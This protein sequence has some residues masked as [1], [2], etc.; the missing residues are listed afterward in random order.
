MLSDLTFPCYLTT[1]RGRKCLS[2]KVICDFFLSRLSKF[3][4]SLFM[5]N[6]ICVVIS[7]IYILISFLYVILYLYIYICSCL[8]ARTMMNFLPLWR[9]TSQGQENSRWR[10]PLPSSPRLRPEG[11]GAAWKDPFS[12]NSNARSAGKTGDDADWVAQ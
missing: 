1:F 8:S 5:R 6:F 10:H 2:G 4:C 3:S 12:R 11:R 9:T 7:F